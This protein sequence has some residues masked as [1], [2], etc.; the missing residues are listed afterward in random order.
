MKKINGSQIIAHILF[1]MFS[2]ACLIPLILL[3]SSSLSTKEEVVKY[4]IG[5]FPRRPVMDSYNM[6]FEH[7]A[8]LLRSYGVSIFITVVGTVVN[9]ILC[10]MTAYS[11]ARKNFKMRRQVS[12]FLYFTMLFSGGMIPTYMLISKYLHMDNTIWV[13]IIPALCAPMT[14]F[15]MRTYLYNVPETLFEAAKIDGASEYTILF[16][17]VMPMSV[18]P[19]AIIAFQTAIGYW[20]SWYEAMLFITDPKLYPIQQ[21]LQNILDYVQM[22]KSAEFANSL[23]SA[24]AANVP[25]NAVVSA[26]CFI[27]IAPVL[28]AY[29][30]FQKWFVQG[31]TAGA[32]K[33]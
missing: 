13:L 20:N 3:V 6:V 5:L 4:G 2:I 23:L 21:F 25:S 19:M 10:L 18:T 12:F 32:V 22:L 1:M 28:L 11:L 8:R 9:V 17:I 16:K 24:Q 29:L 27:T 14:I 30:M 33:E 7:P 31:I 15:L 26:T